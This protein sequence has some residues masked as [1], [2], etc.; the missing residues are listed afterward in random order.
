ME[1]LTE[2]DRGRKKRRVG[3]E[4]DIGR[5]PT[6]KSIIKSGYRDY[7]AL[8]VFPKIETEITPLIKLTTSM[9]RLRAHWRKIALALVSIFIFAL[10]LQV[11]K[12]GARSLEPLIYEHL[13]VTGLLDGMG[14]GWLGAVLILSGSPIAAMALALTDAHVVT[15]IAAFG[16]INGSRIGAA[17]IVLLIGLIYSIRRKSSVGK[18]RSAM[19]VG[20]LA[21]IVA[22]TVQVP[23]IFIGFLLLKYRILNSLQLGEVQ[24]AT[25]SV[26]VLFK[27]ILNLL[28][29]FMPNWSLFFVGMAVM[30]FSFRLFDRALPEISL[31]N[32]RMITS[33]RIF[34]SPIVMFLLGGTVTLVTLSVSVSLGLMVPLVARNYIKR[35]TLIPYIMGAGITTFVDT[36]A[37]ALLLQNPIAVTLVVVEMITI[38]LVSLSYILLGFRTYERWVQGAVDYMLNHPKALWSYMTVFIL[39]P[40]LLV[41]V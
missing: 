9:N 31:D 22:Q 41:I 33:S 14:F 10:A 11:L 6:K 38:S 7:T 3:E 18:P 30:M 40:L 13:Q 25:S 36:L 19:G 29:G 34:H 39:L 4:K 28:T 23:A 37:T 2:R 15:P 35:Q 12:T 1:R 21:L 26:D 24:D 8:A 27:P 32:E 16:M 17:F 5:L 20:L